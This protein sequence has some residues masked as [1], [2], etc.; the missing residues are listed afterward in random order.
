MS[1]EAPVTV[2]GR[3]IPAEGAVRLPAQEASAGGEPADR[4]A[5]RGGAGRTWQVVGGALYIAMI[6]LGAATLFA[7]GDGLFWRWIAAGA[8]CAYAPAAGALFAI[9]GCGHGARRP[10]R[11]PGSG[12][13]N[14]QAR[15]FWLHLPLLLPA[16]LLPPAA[17]GIA[18]W[19]R[20]SWL[21]VALGAL[22]ALESMA[23]LPLVA[24]FYICPHCPQK[25]TCPWMRGSAQA[26]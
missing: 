9:R 12:P 11:P 24:R 5:L 25:D 7:S 18:I 1:K 22:F 17:A 10:A 8:Y 14:A 4:C 2:R 16:W 3:S 19:L 13:G 21:V 26:G 6:A 20:F 15:G 23:V